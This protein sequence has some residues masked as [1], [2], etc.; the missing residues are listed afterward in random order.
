M[1]YTITSDV[2]A[3]EYDSSTMA[4]REDIS[5]PWRKFKWAYGVLKSN[6]SKVVGVIISQHPY[7]IQIPTHYHVLELIKQVY[8]ID[9]TYIGCRRTPFENFTVRM[10]AENFNKFALLFSNLEYTIWPYE[11]YHKSIS[12][13]VFGSNT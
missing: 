4:W 12:S 5:Q 8:G 3:I 10:S 13:I 1:I 9:M 7:L 6:R 11:E 2:T